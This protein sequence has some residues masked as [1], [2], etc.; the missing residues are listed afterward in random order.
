MH[1]RR[2]S[3]CR[4]KTCERRACRRKEIAR[5]VYETDLYQ[6][7]LYSEIKEDVHVVTGKCIQKLDNQIDGDSYVDN[8]EC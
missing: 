2:Y 1:G 5:R 3:R 7:K 6:E 8:R 4:R